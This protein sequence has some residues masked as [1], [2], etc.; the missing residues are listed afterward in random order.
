M[1]TKSLFLQIAILASV[2]FFAGCASEPGAVA[3][4][5]STKYTLENTDNFEV[6]GQSTQTAVT[7]TGLQPRMLPDGRLEVVASVK[8]RADQ[9]LKIQINCVFKDEQGFTTGDE[10]PLQTL[11]L[12]A[13][14]T[15]AVRFT[16][17]NPLARK[18]TIR[19]REVR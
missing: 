13:H 12:A 10:T 14:A 16:A 9:P 6:L 2:A 19:V 7:C 3:P 4:Q 8:N 5:D 15:E 18:Y 1:K 11:T 17:A